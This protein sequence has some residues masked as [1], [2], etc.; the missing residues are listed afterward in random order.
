MNVLVL[1]DT[2]PNVLA[3]WR[4]PYNRRQIEC[5]SKL[6]RVTV[7]NPFPW[8]RLFMGRQCRALTNGPDNVLD[9]IPVYHPVF[10]YLPIIGR[11]ATWRRVTSAAERA[12]RKYSLGWTGG[13]NR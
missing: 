10:W 1:S 9:G 7:I 4:G 2:F 3:P 6:C 13:L 12:L 11:N 5:L 8:P